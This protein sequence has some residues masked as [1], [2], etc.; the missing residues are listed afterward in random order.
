MKLL[1]WGISNIGK[2][3]ICKR[4]SKRINCKFYEIDEEIIKVYGSI[5]NFREI[6][7]DNYDRY[8]EKEKL[9]LDIINYEEDFIM[10]ASPIFFFNS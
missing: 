2:S 7:P 10:E 6:F 5:E 8:Q 3:T 4:L 9:M 1:I